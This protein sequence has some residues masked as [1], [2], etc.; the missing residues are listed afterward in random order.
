MPGLDGLRP[1]PAA[2][3]PWYRV[4]GD[5]DRLLLEHGQTVVVLEGA[6]VRTLLPALLPLLDGTRGVEELVVRLGPAARPAV[7]LALE[8]LAS[9]GL[10]VEGP[11]A[12][13]AVRVTAH[14]LASA[15][16][17]APSVAAGRL[18]DAVVGVVGSSALGFEI[19]RLLRLAGVGEVRRVRWLRPGENDIVVVAPAAYEAGK[20]AAWNRAALVAGT[21][22]L[23]VRAYDGRCASVGPL[24]VPG[25]SCCYQCLLLRRAANAEWGDDMAMVEEAPLAA[26]ADPG[27]DALVVALAAHL[28]IRWVAGG[29]TSLPGVLFAVEERPLPRIGQHAVVRVPRCPACSPVERVARPL[30]WHEAAA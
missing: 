13:P 30:P 20:L 21:R 4:V 5:D 10:L 2:A 25:E 14:A 3:R 26:C 29:D 9:H 23:L 11:D 8:T 27:L 28:A 22:W 15:Y 19:A 16:D 6:A 17:L 7:D 12:P 24:V 18:R 1:P